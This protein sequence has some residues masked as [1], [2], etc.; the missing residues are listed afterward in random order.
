[1]EPNRA[2]ES[3]SGESDHSD[4]SADCL[5]RYLEA[6]RRIDAE[7]K[8]IHGLA[9]ILSKFEQFERDS[10]EV[11]PV[12]LGLIHHTIEQSVS[13][14]SSSLNEFMPVSERQA[15]PNTGQSEKSR[16]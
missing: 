11:D 7:I 1:M 16:I 4:M 15:A 3:S 14:I 2:L 9:G 10:M 6:R 8:L 5:Q 13:A 12:A